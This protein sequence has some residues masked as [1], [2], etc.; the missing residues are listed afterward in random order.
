MHSPELQHLQDLAEKQGGL[1]LNDIYI[2]PKTKY[3]WQCAKGHIWKQSGKSIQLGLW[4]PVCS[5][6][7]HTPMIEQYRTIAKLNG[8]LLISSDYLGSKIPHKWQCAEGHQWDA[9]GF[10]VLAGSWCPTCVNSNLSSTEIEKILNECA[11]RKQG[12]VLSTTFTT[13]GAL[14]K[15]E[16]AYKHQWSISGR[17]ILNGTW[18][19]S[20]AQGLNERKVIYVAEQVTGLVFQK[21]RP[22]WLLNTNGYPLELDGYNEEYG[23]AIEYQGIQHYHFIKAWHKTTERFNE[24]KQR[25]ALK[26]QSCLDR[27]IAFIEIPY[28]TPPESFEHEILYQ[29]SKYKKLGFRIPEIKKNDIVIPDFLHSDFSLDY[30]NDLAAQKEGS[31]NNVEYKGMAYTYSWSC[32]QGHTWNARASSIQDGTWCPYCINNRIENPLTKLLE[33]GERY[34]ISLQEKEYKNATTQYTWKCSK[35]HEWKGTP[36]SIKNIKGCPECLGIAPNAKLKKL[37]KLASEN[38]YQLLSSDYKN[39]ETNYLF[40]CAFGH[41]WEMLGKRVFAGRLKCGECGKKM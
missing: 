10:H 41:T 6:K 25:D 3:T 39:T 33:L 36:L 24:L 9:I 29:L 1:L 7:K 27:N 16:C 23:I 18:C 12:R 5:D 20:C 30:L 11:S 38:G 28:T 2:T 4:C 22:S 35:N 17:N 32:K 37:A 21:L 13:L 19:P 8:G 14:Y 40:S 15:W 31:C 26:K 34:Q